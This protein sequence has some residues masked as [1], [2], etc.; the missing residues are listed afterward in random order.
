MRVKILFILIFG[1]A[2]FIPTLA[3]ASAGNMVISEISMG[4]ENSAS[5]E[6]VELYNNSINPIDASEWSLYYKSATGISWTKK[7]SVPINTVVQPHNFLL[8]STISGTDVHLTSGMAQTGGVI[9]LR[10]ASAVAIDT[11]GWGTA[12]LSIGKPAVAAQAGESLYRQYDENTQTM[13][14]SDDNLSDYYITAQMTP[15]GIPA[16]E[17]IDPQST[18]SYPLISVSELYPNPS[19][20]QSEST[21]EFIELYNP[22]DFDVDLNGWLLKDASDKTYIIKNKTL[23]AKSY[24]AFMS[25]ETHISLNNTGDTVRLVSPSGQLMDESAD[26]GES[27][28]GLSWSVVG[29]SWNWTVTPSPSAVNSA[30]YV[31]NIVKP[32][33]ETASSTTAKK[34]IKKASVT[35]PK[36]SKAASKLVSSAKAAPANSQGSDTNTSAQSTLANIWPWLLIVLGIGTIGYGIY[37]YRPEITTFYYRLKDKFSASN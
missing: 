17:V 2:I 16:P 32:V 7:A 23:P 18:I 31:E 5:E 19:G 6:F 24:I 15:K 36:T 3:H 12:D 28:E 33:G 14:D 8:I 13:V 35:T 29:D 10:S 34:A 4:S 37:E 26:Y 11:I 1:F 25:A 22:N 21:D 30:I 27:K 20:E 9:Q